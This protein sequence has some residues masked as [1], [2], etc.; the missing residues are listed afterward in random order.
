[1][2]RVASEGLVLAEQKFFFLRN[3]GLRSIY[4]KKKVG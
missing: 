1:M 3:D 2:T 4:L